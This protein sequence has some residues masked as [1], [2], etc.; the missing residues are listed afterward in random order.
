MNRD[1]YNNRVELPEEVIVY[2][3]QCHD[4][5]P[6]SNQNVEG[7]KRN[8]ELR[9]S[10]YV[11]YQQLKRI[12]NFFDNFNGEDNDLTFISNGGHYMKNWV[13]QTLNSM[14]N[15]NQQSK[16]IKSVVLPNQF[17]SQHEKNKNL[18]TKNHQTNLDRYNLQVTESLRRINELI[19][20]II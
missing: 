15:S 4:E 20:K 3:K 18:N 19:K 12:K 11:T 1:L 9:D 8:K 10:G 6:D 13:N 7:L 17:I 16:E 2:L 5:I 14:R